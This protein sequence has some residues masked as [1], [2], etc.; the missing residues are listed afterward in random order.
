LDGV[1]VTMQPRD[2]LDE[3]V[4]FA[5]DLP[6][7]RG[8]R[9]RVMRQVMGFLAHYRGRLT[10]LQLYSAVLNGALI[11]M[12][13]FASSPNGIGSQRPRQT[14]LA[15]T[16]VLDPEYTP[17]IRVDANFEDHF[18]PTMV[19]DENGPLSVDLAEDLSV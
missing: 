5:R 15:G 18:R 14:Y 11:C 17:M 9:G 3:V 16:E 10:P 12:E 2:P 7:L 6:S 4:R 1:T 13:T 19:T 8:Y